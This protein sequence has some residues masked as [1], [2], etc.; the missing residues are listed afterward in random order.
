MHA[1][2]LLEYAIIASAITSTHAIYQSLINLHKN[3]INFLIANFSFHSKLQYLA[4]N[5][6]LQ[7]IFIIHFDICSRI[8]MNKKKEQL[9][10]IIT[11]R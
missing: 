11:F 5:I 2:Q 1:I 8:K 9:K 7:N 6:S 10:I 3:L 4:K